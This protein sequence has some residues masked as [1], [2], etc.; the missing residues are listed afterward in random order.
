[1][2][3]VF[4]CWRERPCCYRFNCTEDNALDSNNSFSDCFIK[5][6]MGYQNSVHEKNMQ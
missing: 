6:N 4:S 3:Q 1:V 2:I 5:Y